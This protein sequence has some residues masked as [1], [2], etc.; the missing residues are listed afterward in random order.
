MPRGRI[1]RPRRRGGRSG[2][3]QPIFGWKNHAA[4]RR[5]PILT[6][7]T[8]W[9]DRRISERGGVVLAYCVCGNPSFS[10]RTGGPTLNFSL[11]IITD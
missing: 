6:I 10:E 8:P 11:Q 5:V 1:K 2:S 4:P 7:R 3:H 9:H